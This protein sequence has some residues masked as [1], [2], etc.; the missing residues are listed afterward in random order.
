MTLITK[1]NLAMPGNLPLVAFTSLHNTEYFMHNNTAYMYI[2]I[3]DN[4]NLIACLRSGLGG[5]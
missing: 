5:L 3:D 1:H 2:H 4:C